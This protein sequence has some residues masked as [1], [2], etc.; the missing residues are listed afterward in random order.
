MSDNSDKPLVHASPNGDMDAGKPHPQQAPALLPPHKDVILLLVE[1]FGMIC[2][3]KKHRAKGCQVQAIPHLDGG[4]IHAALTGKCE[5]CMAE[6]HFQFYPRQQE[7]PP[8]RH[9]I[10]E[11]RVSLWTP[12]D[13]MPEIP[14]A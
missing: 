14:K 2:G 9:D 1:I 13:P 3:A 8:I 5:V 12:G 7:G 11:C 6:L 10:G 4:L